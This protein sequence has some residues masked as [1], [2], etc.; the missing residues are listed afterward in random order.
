MA[1][2]LWLFGSGL[3]LC[4]LT[5]CNSSE[6]GT[7][8]SG[9]AGG[10]EQRVSADGV[11]SP[12]ALLLTGSDLN[13]VDRFW[14]CTYIVDGEF[15]DRKQIHLL[16]GGVA[17][18]DGMASDWG[19]QEG[20]L[21]IS[22]EVSGI[23]VDS[24]EFDS[25]LFASDKF[26]AAD[27]NGLQLNCDW[28]GPARPGSILLN[29]SVY[30][31]LDSSG[32]EIDTL[33]VT[34]NVQKSRSS[35]WRCRS[36]VHGWE[37]SLYMFADGTIEFDETGR[38]VATGKDSIEVSLNS[39]TQYWTDVKIAENREVRYDFFEAEVDGEAMAC[40]WLGE[41]RASAYTE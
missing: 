26:S 39:G 18:V 9:G 1:K 22:N 11:T 12:G 23:V 40:D 10:A 27:A 20:L 14:F 25:R 33:L 31:S 4:V 16:D 32:D 24:V 21:S 35:H 15:V 13:D 28:S 7:L 6:D 17:L 38:W 3:A 29:D 19:Y 8:V 2:C 5:A 34:G 36:L 41:P 37:R 30:E